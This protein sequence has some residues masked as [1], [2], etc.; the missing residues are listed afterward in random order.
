LV[1]IKII[2]M[3]KYPVEVG[4]FEA[5][6][7]GLNMQLSTKT[8]KLLCKKISGKSSAEA[9][10]FLEGLVNKKI[11]INRK[12]HSKVAEGIL[13]ILRSAIA[14][15]T[16]KGLTEPLHVKLAIAEKG[17]TRRRRRRVGLG[18]KIKATNIKIILQGGK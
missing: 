11:K 16:Y 4:K 3:A 10:A 17:W 12:Y 15:A 14:N 5:A 6:A 2:L 13:E 9:V 8:S 1:V 18:S 7:S